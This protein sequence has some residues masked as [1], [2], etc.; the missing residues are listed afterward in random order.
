MNFTYLLGHYKLFRACA[1][2]Y[3]KYDIIHIYIYIVENSKFNV[4]L[5]YKKS[6]KKSL[7]L[8]TIFF[9]FDQIQILVSQS[10]I[11]ISKVKIKVILHIPFFNNIHASI[12]YACFFFHY[13]KNLSFYFWS[14]N[15][16]YPLFLFFFF[17]LC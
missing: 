1:F 6:K 7:L 14:T 2:F 4:P 12:V 15:T 11:F 13:T 8:D 9:V 5:W 3:V 17:Y 16:P 10:T